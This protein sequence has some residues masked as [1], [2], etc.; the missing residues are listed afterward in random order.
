MKYLSF[1]VAFLCLAIDITTKK[2]ATNAL[3]PGATQ[4][5]IAGLLEANLTTNRG[6]AFGLG[7]NSGLLMTVVSVCVFVFL[8][9]WIYNREKSRPGAWERAGMGFLV[10]G[11]IGNILERLTA[12]QVTD[13]LEFSFVSFPIFNMADVF[14]DIGVGIIIFT[15]LVRGDSKQ[16]QMSNLETKNGR[17]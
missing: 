7:Q 14:I 13:F 2:W 9:I 3:S 10:G 5:L 8:L 6:A 11:A 1:T 15:H 4:I 16:N 12:G 17:T